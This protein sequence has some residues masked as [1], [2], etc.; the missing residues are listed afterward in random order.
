[1]AAPTEKEF[2]KNLSAS[3]TGIFVPNLYFGSGYSYE[4]SF[5]LEAPTNIHVAGRIFGK[6]SYQSVQFGMNSATQT[7]GSSSVNI[8]FG[9][10]DVNNR[11]VVVPNAIPFNSGA[12][13]KD[14]VVKAT[15]LG[16]LVTVNGETSSVNYNNPTDNVVYGSC[17]F[18]F[19]RYWGTDTDDGGSGV[20][21]VHFRYVKISDNNNNLVNYF[22]PAIDY[23]ARPCLYDKVNDVCYYAANDGYISCYNS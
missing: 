22:V 6:S 14:C 8:Y 21:F 23:Q 4:A 19:M 2:M 1:M 12:I 5:V 16:A 9:Y 17:D 3:N 15:N 11:D 13:T 20:D 18:V 7:G 10:D